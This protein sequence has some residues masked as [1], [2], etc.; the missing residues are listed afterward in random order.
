MEDIDKKVSKV[1][2]LQDRLNRAME[3]QADTESFKKHYQ[4]KLKEEEKANK[5]LMKCNQEYKARVDK[6]N[7]ENT[8]LRQGMVAKE[9]SLI[10]TVKTLKQQLKDKESKNK[11]LKAELK[12]LKTN[13]N[14]NNRPKA[15]KGSDSSWSEDEIV[16]DSPNLFGA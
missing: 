2:Q 15:P 16:T 8:E 9:K 6:L 12:T 14:Q 10:E 3:K 1:N 7:R 4:T 5:E 11:G 13:S